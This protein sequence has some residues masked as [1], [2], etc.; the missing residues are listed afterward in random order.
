M[1][2]YLVHGPFGLNYHDDEDVLPK[3]SDGSADLDLDTDIIAVW[4]VCSA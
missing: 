4:K 2:L 3:K 1:D